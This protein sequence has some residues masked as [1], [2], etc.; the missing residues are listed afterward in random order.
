MRRQ[1]LMMTSSLALLAA[2]PT[3]LPLPPEV[4]TLITNPCP[5]ESY[6]E[7]LWRIEQL[8]AHDASE[9]INPVCRTRFL[10]HGGTSERAIL[11]LHGYTNCPQQFATLGRR[12]HKMGYNVLIPRLPHNGLADRLNEEHAQITAEK[13]IGFTDAMID[14]THGLGRHVTVAGLSASGVLT[15]W[16]AQQRAD[17]DRAVIMSPCFAPPNNR[18]TAAISS[19]TMLL[20]L[21]MPNKFIWWD[22]TLKADAPAPRHTYPR[23]STHALA[24]V[25]RLGFAVHHEARYTP[26]ATGDVIVITTAKDTAVDNRITYDLTRLWREQRPAAIREHIFT[27]DMCLP[28]DFIDPDQVD[29]RVPLVYPILSD[30]IHGA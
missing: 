12:L 16:A 18:L 4:T 10:T 15:A 3:A 28:H 13:L 20:G 26:P 2:L 29:Q 11:F 6:T 25:M 5:V 17:I 8:Q 23:F 7:A 21:K 14:I 19:R 22:K 24:E 30:L 1:L 27:E 9:P